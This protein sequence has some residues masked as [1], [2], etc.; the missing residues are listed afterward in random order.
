[1]GGVDAR[2]DAFG[3]GRAGCAAPGLVRS[4]AS[5]T[6]SNMTK[7][8]F[9]ITTPIYYVNS[10]PHVGSAYT[11][12]VADV[13]ARWH[14]LHGEKVHFLTGVDEHG[15]KQL[16]SAEEAGVDPQ[17]Y[18]NSMAP[19]FRELWQSLE[20]TN[21]DFIRTTEERHKS[22]VVPFMEA[23]RATDDIYLGTYEGWYC[24]RCEEFKSDDE[25]IDGNC[26][27]HGSPVEHLAEDNYFFRLSKY[28]DALL[29]LYETN[30]DF[31][32]PKRAYNE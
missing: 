20:I 1:G 29:E 32:R 13:I 12:I 3:G 17:T 22:A 27:I 26:A 11:T 21:D 5:S 19:H 31:L 8:T 9:Y 30:P 25:L 14:R 7:D 16:K 28:N 10:I 15:A 23:L 4:C 18:V 24:V 2:S 6:E